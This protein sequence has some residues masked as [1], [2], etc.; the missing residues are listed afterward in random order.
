[1]RRCKYRNTLDELREAL[2]TGDMNA[3]WYFDEQGIRHTPIVMYARNGKADHVKLLIERGADVNRNVYACNETALHSAVWYNH[4]DVV[5]VLLEAG[6]NVNP[7]NGDGFTPLDY[8][9]DTKGEIA[10]M[11]RE[12][13]GLRTETF[14]GGTRKFVQKKEEEE[15][16][17][18]VEV[19]IPNAQIVNKKE[20]GICSFL[21]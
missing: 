17:R 1:M 11:L 13:G 4:V 5:R 9:C 8:V 20:E 2:D 14:E 10:K 19:H 16:K 3:N 15:M 12:R 6:T 7:V 18:E 21:F